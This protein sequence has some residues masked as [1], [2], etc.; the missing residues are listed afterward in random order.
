MG[1]ILSLHL[2]HSL[3]RQLTHPTVLGTDSQAVIRAL[4]NQ[5]SHSGHYLLD[6]IHLAAERLHAKQ[7][8]LINQLECSQAIMAGEPWKGDSRGVIDLQIHWVPGHCDFGPNE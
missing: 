1:L 6:V 8:G 2:L 3:T 7:D 5:R 4:N